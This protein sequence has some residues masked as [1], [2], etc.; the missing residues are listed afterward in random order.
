[1]IRSKNQTNPYNEDFS[2]QMSYVNKKMRDNHRAQNYQEA[3]RVQETQDDNS[4]FIKDHFIFSDNGNDKPFIIEEQ[5]EMQLPYEYE[6]ITEQDD[7]E[8]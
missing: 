4:N 2:E 3:L 8:S 7:N 1:M 6:K 5:E